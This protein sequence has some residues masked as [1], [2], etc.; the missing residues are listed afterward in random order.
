MAD[1]LR[2]AGMLVNVV[3][4]PELCDFTTPSV[5]DRDPVLVAIGTGGASAGLA[6]HLRLRLEALLPE[7]IGRLASALAS[8][9]DRIRARWP[10]AAERR[11]ALDA[12]L[13]EGGPLDPLSGA[14]Q[15][16]LAGWLAAGPDQKPGSSRIE[17]SVPADPADLT[18]RQLQLLGSADTILFD[19]AVPAAILAK[20]RADADRRP[21]EGAS[22]ED[23]PG[24][25]LVLNCSEAP[26]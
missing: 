24:L 13:G 2:A 26:R 6:K 8:S 22:T 5:L 20:A 25:T 19:S 3:D 12:A 11:R 10:D 7:S 4:R 23:G 1:R 14:G 17:I 15:D 18:L 21:L 16:E 9:R